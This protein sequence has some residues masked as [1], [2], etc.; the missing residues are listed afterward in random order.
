VGPHM[1]ILNKKT[2]LYGR[3]QVRTFRNYDSMEMRKHVK[4]QL[5]GSSPARFER[6][7]APIGGIRWPHPR[8]P[9]RL[10]VRLSVGT[11]RRMATL[12]PPLCH[13]ARPQHSVIAEIRMNT[14]TELLT[15]VVTGLRSHGIKDARLLVVAE[16]RIPAATDFRCGVY[17]ALQRSALSCRT[18]GRGDRRDPRKE[19][20]RHVRPSVRT[21]GFAELSKGI[22]QLRSRVTAYVRRFSGAAYMHGHHFIS[23][24]RYP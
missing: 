4:P 19:L 23:S 16:T 1:R 17:A 22:P 18:P 6:R 20:R 7:T 8:P 5:R 11:Q 3:P 14:D 2:T 9:G 13:L 15:Y 10:H 12:L 21:C 24:C